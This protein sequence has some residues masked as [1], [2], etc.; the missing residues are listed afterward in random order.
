MLFVYR[1]YDLFV[2]LMVLGLYKADYLKKNKVCRFYYTAV[3]RS[4]KVEPVNG[5]ITPVGWLS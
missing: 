1:L 3:A 4:G 2:W 5:L